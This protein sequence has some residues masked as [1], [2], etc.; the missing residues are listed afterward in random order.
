MAKSFEDRFFEMV[1]KETQATLFD[2]ER[3]MQ[4]IA[5]L[6]GA[7]GSVTATITHGRQEHIEK[8]LFESADLSRR[9]ADRVGPI[10]RQRWADARA[11]KH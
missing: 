10:I 7:L 5:N 2:H 3:A 1:H 11:G 6:A 4:L 9:A 8:I